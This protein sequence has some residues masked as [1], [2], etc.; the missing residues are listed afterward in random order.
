MILFSLHLFIVATCR[1]GR[2]ALANSSIDS[3]DSAGGVILAGNGADRL[4]NSLDQMG[5]AGFNLSGDGRG[6][7]LG[8]KESERKNESDV[9]RRTFGPKYLKQKMHITPALAWMTLEHVSVAC[10]ARRA[11]LANASGKRDGFTSGVVSASNFTD[12]LADPLLQFGAVSLNLGRNG[13]G[14]GLRDEKSKGKDKSDGRKSELH[15]I[16]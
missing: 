16:V 9:K 6:L 8:H 3:N 7:D 10:R 4:A 13:R 2:A 12:V 11:R 14:T 15:F 1:A 5:V